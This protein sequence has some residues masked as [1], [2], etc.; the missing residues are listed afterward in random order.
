MGRGSCPRTAVS[1]ALP[2]DGGGSFDYGGCIG[3]CADRYAQDFGTCASYGWDLSW[4]ASCTIWAQV[5]V[6]GCFSWCGA[7]AF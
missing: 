7:G 3:G 5:K 6:Q 2:N 1:D 4:F